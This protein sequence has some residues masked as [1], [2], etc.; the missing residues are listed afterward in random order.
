MNAMIVLVKPINEFIKKL[1]YHFI[2][3]Y[4]VALVFS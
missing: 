3:I 4:F 1:K 2:D